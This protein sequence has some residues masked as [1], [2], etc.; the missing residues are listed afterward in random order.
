VNF[1]LPLDENRCELTLAPPWKGLYG[2]KVV[3]NITWLQM[4]HLVMFCFRVL[5]RTCLSCWR[6]F[7]AAG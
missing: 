4:L 2:C 1:Y 7:R 6:E 3:R 5:L